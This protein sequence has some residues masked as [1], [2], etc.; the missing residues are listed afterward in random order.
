MR[1]EIDSSHDPITDIEISKGMKGKMKAR[2]HW[3]YRWVKNMGYWYGGVES[4]EDIPRG[5]V[6]TR[7][8]EEGQV[9]F[10]LGDK[11][12]VHTHDKNPNLWAGVPA[13]IIPKQQS[14]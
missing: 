11:I 9:L 2:S 4:E 12:C 1:R 14:A 3:E 13:K 5:A 8:T 6:E 7:F 10:E